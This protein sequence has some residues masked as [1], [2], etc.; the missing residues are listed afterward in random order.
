[1][2]T[3]EH[4]AASDAAVQAP[5]AQRRRKHDLAGRTASLLY[6]RALP[7]PLTGCVSALS[8]CR[9]QSSGYHD[10]LKNF[11]ALCTV[12][13]GLSAGGAV[14]H[15]YDALGRPTAENGCGCLTAELAEIQTN[16]AIGDDD[17]EFCG[18][19]GWLHH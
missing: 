18:Y 17:I 3:R 5:P 13:D 1:M 14:P 6:P 12:T 19:L 15:D 10:A 16:F 11:A 2:S 9:C 8:I 4:L 7:R